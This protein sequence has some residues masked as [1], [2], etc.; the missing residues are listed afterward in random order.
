VDIYDSATDQWSTATLSQA[1]RVPSATSV[2]TKVL[3]A[4]GV[5]AYNTYSN[6]VDIY[7]TVTGVWSTATLSVPRGGIAATRIGTKAYFAGGVQEDINGNNISSRVIDIY[8]STTELWTTDTLPNILG[9]AVATSVGTKVLFATTGSQRNMVDIYD[10]ATKLWSMAT[11]SQSRFDLTATSAGEKAFFAGGGYLPPNVYSQSFS[12]V[13]DI[14][15]NSTGQWTTSKLSQPRSALASTSYGGKA[16][17]AVGYPGLFT[18]SDVVD[19]YETAATS[20]SII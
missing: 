4:G 9:S 3:I 7:D 5:L 8:D 15:D 11:L 6:V 1:R 17:F 10:D 14:Y 13:V 19:I 12:D 16:F 2:G 18:F 20:F